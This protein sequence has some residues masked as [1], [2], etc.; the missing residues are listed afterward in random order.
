MDKYIGYLVKKLFQ[1]SDDLC[2]KGS[3]RTASG[4]RR[5]RLHAIRC[6]MEQHNA[7]E[8]I[9]VFDRCLLFRSCKNAFRIRIHVRHRPVI[10]LVLLVHSK[11][12]NQTC[13][14][15]TGI[16]QCDCRRK[17]TECILT[18]GCGDGFV[19]ANKVPGWEICG[20]LES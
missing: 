12:K 4:R 9:H 14:R 1:F 5:C 7:C 8:L 2:T 13:R 6:S 17:A 10:I 19:E 15:L 3:R 18:A 20:G 16:A 11:K